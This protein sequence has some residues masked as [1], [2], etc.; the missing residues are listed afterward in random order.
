M[1]AQR[2]AGAG[3]DLRARRMRGPRVANG[4]DRM[5]GRRH[6][7]SALDILLD[8]LAT[9]GLALVF[10]NV[11]AEQL[12]LPLPAYP[13]LVV[14][15]AWTVDRQQDMPSL[16]AVAV[17]ASLVADLFWFASGR[18]YGAVVL[19]TV[20]RISLSPDS[21]V[22]Q[23][24]SLFARWGVWSLLVAKFIPGFGTVATALSGRMRMPLAAFIAADFVGALL[25]AAGG[26][27]LGR[28]FHGAVDEVLAVLDRLGRIGLVALLAALACFIAAKW[29]Q[30]QRLLRELRMTRITVPELA[31]MLGGDAPPTLI[32]ARSP[33]SR[34][35]D[36]A[37][38]GARVWSAQSRELAPGDLP[39]DADVVVYCAC[40]NEASAARL[41]R[42]MRQAGFL[43]VRPL[44][45]GI[46]AWIAAGLPIER[47][48]SP[49]PAD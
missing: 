12:G 11:L 32:D 14:M 23:T 6:H 20:C 49:D 46:D 1:V 2:G 15:G 16:L 41:A 22:R 47:L 29:W 19:R 43:R 4:C 36:G 37:I 7:E 28:V 30:R 35:R 33:S 26:I 31:R 40:P 21:C 48:A 44:H 24:E 18:R 9:Y 13:V 5:R 17:A 27:V 8:I 34:Q 42:Q 45:G 38:P 39:A 10:V 3:R 25:Y